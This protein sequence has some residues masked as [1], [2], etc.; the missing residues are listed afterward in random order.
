MSKFLRQSSGLVKQAT[1]KDL[2]M[3]NV[4]NMGA[5]LA[6]FQGISPYIVPGARLW[7]ASL[8]TFLISLP[9][10]L[11]Y[12]A[13]MTRMPRTGGDY[14]WLSRK[15]NGTLGSIMGIAIAFNMPPFFALSAFFSVSAINAV[16]SE[17]GV[18][19][20]VRSLVYLSNNVFVNPYGTL[21]LGQEL[22]IYGLSALAFLVIIAVNI[23]KP[24]WGYSLTTWLGVFASATLALGVVMI[25][26]NAGDFHQ[27]VGVFLSRE[28]VTPS[29]YGGPSFSLGSTVYMIPYFASYA[30]IWLYAGPAVASEAKG[31][32]KLN[33]VLGSLLTTA[34]ITIPFLVMDLVGGYT[35]NASLYP[36]F[37]YNFWTA[38]IAVSPLPV[39]WL[40]GLGLISWNFFV[41]AFGVVVFSRYIFAF[42]F[43]RIFPSAFAKL[44]RASSPYVA[45][46]LDLILTLI[47]L[48]I[49]LISVNGAESL[50]AYTPLAA[51]YLFLVGLTGVKV[52]RS[53]GKSSL[54]IL[55]ALSSAFMAFLAYESVTNPFFGVVSSSG[56]NV[57]GTGYLVALV[58]SG[59]LIYAVA[60]RL[61]RR[62]GIELRE[63]FREIPP[64]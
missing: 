35:F 4:A 18:L 53:E 38:A 9:L 50:Y 15:L 32:V 58:G 59:A 61:R 39:Q 2:V 25:L 10:V 43:D 62:E 57:I 12:T 30:Y 22:L 40:L 26:L 45:H 56:I 37:T 42:S 6:V 36:S 16:L 27:L 19:D 11:L 8:L 24:R 13:L 63:V 31:N 34:M 28:G 3:L 46:V 14:V 49:P 64:E 47:F 44:N 51:I 60:S 7:V 33:L 29:S 52:G 41:M 17:I 55:G 54:V 5:G 20:N 48:A 23:V 1:L 21:T